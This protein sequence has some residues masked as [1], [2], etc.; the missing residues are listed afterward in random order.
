MIV[1][2]KPLTFTEDNLRSVSVPTGT[3][4]VIFNRNLDTDAEA[5]ELLTIARSRNATSGPGEWLVVQI[6]GRA[7][8]VRRNELKTLAAGPVNKPV[9]QASL[10]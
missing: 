5:E 3:P 9:R 6:L 2:A 8:L 4:V 1:T 10:F 7:R